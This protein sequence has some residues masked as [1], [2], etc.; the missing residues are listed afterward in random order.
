LA[1]RE[2]PRF[3]SLRLEERLKLPPLF[4]PPSF[5]RGS[6]LWLRGFVGLVLAMLVQAYSGLA[7]LDMSLPIA[8][9]LAVSAFSLVA[10]YASAGVALWQTLSHL[11]TH[12]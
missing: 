6:A 11:P 5:T 1:L 10:A 8:L 4:V 9:L 3:W 7:P 12:E 2:I